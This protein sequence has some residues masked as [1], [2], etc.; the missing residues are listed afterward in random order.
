MT[1]L[2]EC[3]VSLFRSHD[4]RTKLKTANKHC[5]FFE[6]EIFSSKYCDFYT[7]NMHYFS[8]ASVIT[9]SCFTFDGVRIMQEMLF[10]KMEGI[11]LNEIKNR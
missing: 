1:N 3:H 7:I 2:I 5:L 8:N 9:Y 10:H 11:A 4:C 6:K